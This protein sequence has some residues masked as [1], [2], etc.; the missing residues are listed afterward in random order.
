MAQQVAFVTG[1]TGLLG[2]NLTRALVARGW[3][4]KALA[5]SAAKA[6]AHFDGVAGVEIVEGDMERAADLRPHLAYV[7]ALFHTAAFFRDGYKGGRHWAALKRVNVDG[8]RALLEAAYA[9]G[10]RRM[11]HTSSIAVL[12]GPPGVPVDETME[13]RIEDADDYYRSKI[14]ADAAVCD[15]LAAHPDFF[16]TLVLPGWMWG[17]GDLGPTSAGQVAL[18]I[19][20]GTLPGI[21]PGS[22]SLVD[23]RDV[24]AHQ[25]AA[26]D[27]GRRGERYLAAG[28][29]MTMR[30]L[31]PLVGRVAGVKT[32]T[33]SIPVPVLYGLAGVQ[34]LYARLSG[35]PVLLSL[36]TVR[37]MAREADRTR[38]DAGKS[39]RELGVDFRP[40]EETV[41]DTINW[42]RNNGWLDGAD[43]RAA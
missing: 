40:V 33:R 37:L 35:K 34:E 10:V 5:R 13:R 42:Y 8:T 30:E 2:N 14:L 29:H 9:A 18:D 32:P 22:V 1:A 27:R 28:R 16:A 38:F 17:P 3:R 21:V 7:D 39:R 41:R 12:D 4:V 43:G 36:A 6:F 15:F 20:R 26:L 11:V 23:A 24:A 25:I 31:I 19:L